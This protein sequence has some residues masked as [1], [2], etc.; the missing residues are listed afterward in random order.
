VTTMMYQPKMIDCLPLN[1]RMMRT[2]VQ[3][4]ELV[5]ELLHIKMAL[6][7][8][9]GANAQLEK[10]F[11]SHDFKKMGPQISRNSSGLEGD[12]PFEGEDINLIVNQDIVRAMTCLDLR[13]LA[14]YLNT[15]IT[16]DQLLA[17]AVPLK[18]HKIKQRIEAKRH[19]Q[20]GALNAAS[21]YVDLR[22]KII[23]LY[24]ESKAT[25]DRDGQVKKPKE[26]ASEI[27]R[28]VIEIIAA[29][30]EKYSKVGELLFPDDP[31]RDPLDPTNRNYHAY[32]LRVIRTHVRTKKNKKNAQKK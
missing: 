30:P 7:W 20:Q 1:N 14:R 13:R 17:N 25:N 9:E 8:L 24:D 11:R 21:F 5:S 27:E 18:N 12:N 15:L 32:I 6:E 3:N 26:Y 31:Q 29:S 19:G 2:L 10:Q 4:P 22:H 16:R 23:K 28:N